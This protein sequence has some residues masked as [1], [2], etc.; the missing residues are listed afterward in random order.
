M[1]VTAPS[2][3]RTEVNDVVR[4]ACGGM[5]FGIPLLYTVEVWWI[6]SVTHPAR[7]L[8]VLAVVFFLVLLLNRTS[9]FRT[10]KDASIADAAKDSVEAMAIG[11]IMVTVVLV[12]IRE[13]TIDSPL[14][15]ALGKIVYEA[16]PFTIGVALAGQFLR[17]GRAPDGD[18]EGG[19]KSAFE[20]T[21]ADVGATL[22][23]AVFVASAIAPTDEVP[24]I[25]TAMRAPWIL[26]IVG[27]S[28]LVSYAI[29][30]EAG[31][32]DQEQRK[33]QDGYIQHPVTETLFCY[34][35]ALLAALAML[36]FF[37]RWEPGDPLDLVLQQ[38]LVLGL[39]AAIG[40]AAGR[41]AV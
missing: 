25:T 13:I 30:F 18:E 6:G 3:A 9:G 24:L 29:V 19:G 2:A 41:L 16:T 32:A 23:G 15:Q 8:F 37:Q 20:A 4:G 27:L 28:L 12:L 17:R 7:L 26:A 33:A 36:W 39:P 34:L 35:L 40:G 10:M 22:L 14:R 31:F 1:V 11:L 5:L 21:I 38:T